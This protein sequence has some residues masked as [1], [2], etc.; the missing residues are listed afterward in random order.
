[1]RLLLT[2]TEVNSPNFLYGESKLA[3]KFKYS[4]TFYSTYADD[5]ALSARHILPIVKDLVDP[6]SVVDVGCGVGTWLKAWLELGVS[7]ITGIDGGYV[8]RSELLIPEDRFTAMDLSA[9]TRLETQFDLVESLE[10]AEHLPESAAESFTAFLCSLGPVVLFSAAIPY[11]HGTN[12]INEQWPDYWA[13]LFIKQGYLTFDVIRDR[14]WDNP[15]IAYYYAQNAILFV[16]AEHLKNIPKLSESRISPA[17]ATLPRV[18][19]RKWQE[20]NERALPLEQLIKMF[21]KST[22]EFGERAVRRIRRVLA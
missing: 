18:H 21:P 3:R 6:R 12:H 16:K 13:K 20:K 9:P 11:Q 19:P 4:S 10:V 8:S 15:N 2:E 7:E 14:V 17:P 22:L 1:M 5:S